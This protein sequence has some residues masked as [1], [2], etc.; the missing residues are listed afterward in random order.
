[1]AIVTDE[2]ARL[3]A[4]VAQQNVEMTQLRVDNTT[5]ANTITSL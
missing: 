5:L 3:N 1:M 2:N 4:L